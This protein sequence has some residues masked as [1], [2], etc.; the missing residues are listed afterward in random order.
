MTSR[1][2]VKRAIHFQGP[3]RIPHLLPDGGEND[4][5]WLWPPGLPPKQDW[6]NYGDEDRMTDAWGVVRHRTA[7]GLHGFGEVLAPPITDINRQAEY[8][9]PELNDPARYGDWRKAIAANADSDNPKYVL[10]VMSYGNFEN[11][12]HLVGLDNLFMGLYEDPDHVRGLLA[13]LA[14]KQR[15]CIRFYRQ[16]GCDGV[17]G[18][19][20]WGLQDRAMIASEQ[21]REFFV[22]HYRENWALAHSLGMDTWLHSCGYT[23]DVLP[24]LK[25][26]G[27]DVAQLD[28]QE[29]M[30]LERLDQVLGG[31]LAFWCPVDIQRT[32][33]E[34][35]TEDIR[36]YVRRM[37]H[38]LGCHNG[39]LIS[40]TY[41]S[42]QDV[43]HAPEKVAAACA[44]F[45]EYE[46]Y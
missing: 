20:D 30:G 8:Q 17:M 25:E 5:L 44:A 36:R 32:M 45:R 15:Q 13:R 1:V 6:I 10:G 16:M 21:L 34:G 9:V 3:D 27:L 22:P 33:V 38:T 18:Y 46:R 43:R 35:T 40:K 29:N 28:Q 7:G 39:G 26:A 2:R 37:I 23:I 12:H 19:D 4:I 41:P 11:C 14:E 42:P 31:K 24:V